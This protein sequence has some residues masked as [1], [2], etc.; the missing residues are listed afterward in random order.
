MRIIGKG[1]AVLL[2]AAS[3]IGLHAQDT[4]ITIPDVK[5]ISDY[6]PF[7]ADAKKETT[8]PTAEP[9]EAKLPSLTYSIIPVQFITTSRL[10]IPVSLQMGKNYTP[11][12]K[13]NHI[14]LGFGNYASPLAEV[15][16]H[17][18]RNEYGAYGLNFKHLSASG[19]D[20]MKFSDNIAQVFGK[21]F[22]KKGTLYAGVDYNR[23]AIR[24]YGFNDSVERPSDDSLKQVFNTIGVNGG[25]ASQ[26][27]GRNKMQFT[28]EASYYNLTDKWGVQE[29]DLNV[30]LGFK[31]NIKKDV[32]RINLGYSFNSYQDSGMKLDRNFITIKPRYLLNEKGFKLSLGFNSTV[33]VDTAKPVLY[34]FPAIDGEYEIEKQNFVALAGIRGDL[35]KNTFRNFMLENPFMGN[36]NNLNNTVNRLEAYIGLRGNAGANFGFTTRLFYN[37]YTDMPVFIADSSALRRFKPLFLDMNVIRFNAELGYQYSEKVR[38]NLTGNFYS[39]DVNDSAQKAWHLPTAELKLNATYNIGDKLIF[40]ADVFFMNKRPVTSEFATQQVADLKAFAD[41]NLGFEYRYRKTLSLFLRLNNVSSVRY[42]RWYNYP[43]YGLNVM[44]G[45]TFSL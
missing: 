31:T 30:G 9:P 27:W 18:L 8:P 20:D 45:I 12:L 39:Y 41:F 26:E 24:Y 7:L 36:Q 28:S 34:F 40:A 4:T 19:P 17:N 29:N 21:R 33:Y 32:L 14:R 38:I 1:L 6:I 42:Q 35:Q 3:Y 2:L 25:W 10:D 15:Y 37:S 22:F 11:T 13:N 43:V 23:N 16:L 44:G 5:V